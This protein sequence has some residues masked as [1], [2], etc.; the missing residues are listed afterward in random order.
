MLCEIGNSLGKNPFVLW[1]ILVSIA[2]FV[3]LISSGIVF[4]DSYVHARYERWVYKT[5][6]KY[7]EY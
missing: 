4:Y 7:R 6:P 3:I 5:N 1:L 2:G